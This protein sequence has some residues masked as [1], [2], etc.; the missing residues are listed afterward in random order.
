MNS[1]RDDYN[2]KINKLFLFVGLLHIPVFLAEAWFFKTEFSIAILGPILIL[3]GPSISYLVKP[4][5]ILTSS[6]NA[7][8]MM[9]MSGV[10]I[11]LG[12]GM[13]EMHFHIFTFLA[14]TI[15]FGSIWPVLAALVTVAVHHIGF[16]FLLPKS[17][18]NYEA[19]FNIVLLHATF[20]IVQSIGCAI[21][22]KKF[23][24]FVD[25]QDTVV[26]NLNSV[27]KT[28][29]DLSQKIAKITTVVSESTDSQA[30][31]VQ[32]TVATLE[33]ISKMVEMTNK[34]IQETESNTSSS[35]TQAETGKTSVNS[36][37]NS[38]QNISQ[39]NRQ[40]ISELNNNMNKIQE[41]TNMIQQIAEKTTIINDIVFQ[42]KLLSFNA[43]VEAA[44][45]GEHG[46]GFA[47]VAEEVG[48]LANV[49]GKASEEINSLLET[50]INHVN[51][52]VRETSSSM[53]K[54]SRE[55]QSVLNDGVNKSKDSIS[56]ING[57][58]ENIR[59]NTELM[60]S[61]ATASDEQSKGVREITDAIRV[62]DNSNHENINLI[63]ELKHLSDSMHSE[64]EVLE[65]VVGSI[66]S[67]LLGK[68][69][70][71]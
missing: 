60:K 45:A 16:F 19:S 69:D 6:L 18:F 58:V 46:K 50:S 24:T 53:E 55:G 44:R 28:N 64:S 15:V 32:Q 42:T 62:I 14:F 43:S 21:I 35:F 71:A 70:A 1:F 25:V 8:A 33:E 59:K 67:R 40:M 57:V 20:A 23:G 22:A 9:C 27:V 10:M 66:N 5:S 51:E 68:K 47:V 54:L 11:H 49:S 31:S 29:K 13:I 48:N 61:I 41:V 2:K 38:I 17:L 7:V 30:A 34:N 65:N 3:L 12:K 39:S 37:T 52:I 63:N 4:S 56:I 26:T 36:V